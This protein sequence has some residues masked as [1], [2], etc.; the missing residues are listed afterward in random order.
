MPRIRTIKPEF[1]TDEV[2]AQMSPL[3]RIAFEGLWCHADKSGRLEDRP[4]RLKVLIL[5]YDSADFEALLGEMSARG[6]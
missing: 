1:F 6:G 5:P 3:A 4:A 2:I